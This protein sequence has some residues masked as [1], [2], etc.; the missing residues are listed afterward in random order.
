[1][2]AAI[3]PYTWLDRDND[4]VDVMVKS[5]FVLT[6]PPNT[7]YDVLGLE[8]QLEHPDWH[9]KYKIFLQNPQKKVTVSKNHRCPEPLLGN[10]HRVPQDEVTAIDRVGKS[11]EED[12]SSGTEYEGNFPVCLIPPGGRWKVFSEVEIFMRKIMP[13]FPCRFLYSKAEIIEAA[14]KKLLGH[15]R[16][17]Q[18]VDEE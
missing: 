18:Y 16:L 2:A 15:P 11:L 8:V 3:P 13:M 1:M 14:T 5:L 7:F 17:K 12:D 10:A 9:E 4:E 6:D